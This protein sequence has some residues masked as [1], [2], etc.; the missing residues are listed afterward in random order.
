ML[1]MCLTLYTGKVEVGRSLSTLLET[2]VEVGS[3][4]GKSPSIGIVNRFL[5]AMTGIILIKMTGVFS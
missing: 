4:T 1:Q 5:I 3:S 2:G